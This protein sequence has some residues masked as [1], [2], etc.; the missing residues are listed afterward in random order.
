[1][2]ESTASNPPNTPQFSLYDA[3]QRIQSQLRALEDDLK[4]TRRDIKDLKLGLDHT[5]SV[6]AKRRFSRPATNDSEDQIKLEITQ[7]VLAIFGELQQPIARHKILNAF[8]RRI[9]QLGLNSTKLVDSIPELHIFIGASGGAMLIP[10]AA[11]DDAYPDDKKA[12]ISTTPQERLREIRRDREE[13]R[14][15]YN[16]FRNMP[17]LTG[18]ELAATPAPEGTPA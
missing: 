16:K 17:V 5:Q 2:N 15:A 12:W 18:G 14:E 4:G 3:L 8:T 7:R 13:T 11:W 1:M 6:L 9:H 10:R